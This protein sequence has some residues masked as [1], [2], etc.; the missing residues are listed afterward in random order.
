MHHWAFPS[1]EGLTSWINIIL[2]SPADVLLFSLVRGEDAQHAGLQHMTNVLAIIN[3]KWLNNNTSVI[4]TQLSIVNGLVLRA[5]L[6]TSCLRLFE[7]KAARATLRHNQYIY[8]KNIKKHINLK[9]LI[10]CVWWD[11]RAQWSFILG[12]YSLKGYSLKGETCFM[13]GKNICVQS[14][15]GSRIWN[16]IIISCQVVRYVIT[17]W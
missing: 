17:I 6:R 8:D 13:T 7:K 10:C 4:V 14:C 2:R 11:R 9:L 15:T 5:L 12:Y 1:Y 3:N 16:I